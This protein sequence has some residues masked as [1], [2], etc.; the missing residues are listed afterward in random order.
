[1]SD[2]VQSPN[3]LVI[4]DNTEL[5]GTLIENNTTNQ[6]FNSRETMQVALD[7][8][9]LLEG[10]GIVILDAD[11]NEGDVNS[12]IDQALKLKQADPTQV[13]MIV[14][15]SEKLAAIL[16]TNI[17]P[18]IYRAFNKPISPNQIFLAFKSANALHQD[19]SAKQAAGEDI[20][21]VG[22]VENKTSIG[23]IA[24]QRKSN[25]MLY[26][27][28]GVLALGVIGWFLFASS[29]EEDTSSIVKTT[30]VETVADE[31]AGPANEEVSEINSLN[32]LAQTA[33]SEGRYTTPKGD[34]ALE[35]YNRVLELDPYDVTAY[36]GK[37]SVAEN[38]RWSFQ[39]LLDNAEFDQALT[40]MNDLQAIEPLNSDN[41]KLQKDLE[42][43]INSHVAKV[44]ESGTAEEIEQTTE[45]LAKIESEFTGSQAAAKAL[46]REQT[47]ITRI[48]KALETNNLIPPKSGNAYS[49]LSDAL[50]KNAISKA[51]I[52]PR[53][54]KL[55][56]QLMELT[57]STLESDNIEEADK[58]AALIK[59]LDTDTEGLK[60][61]S[62]TISDK[63]EEIAKLEQEKAN[64]QKEELAAA[65]SQ[66]EKVVEEPAKIIPAKIISRSVPKYPSRA[67]SSGVEGWVSVSFMINTKGIPE[68][69]KIVESQ[70]EGVFDKSAIKAVKKWRFSPARNERTGL[71]V[72]SLIS[73]T[74]LQ[75]KLG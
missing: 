3:V 15:E 40:V 58:L 60:T 52:T 6:T 29:G 64:K 9:D 45:V 48:D 44:K 74:K 14:G 27:A 70:P 57:Y 13:L 46:K 54:E 10:N 8:P 36:E 56:A 24:E 17:Q 53:L 51:N 59:R 33:I 69:I 71:P 5:V 12:T 42:K 34:N 2:G 25:S 62:E 39:G 75:F 43:A 22:P 4:T 31:V 20:S 63:K 47:L 65:E 61:L 55:S 26:I 32:Q 1:M 73:S 19:L 30:P 50:K 67:Q 7:D 72:E 16:K 37:K 41:Q 23:S 28:A 68:E 66:E 18:L 35:Y 49:L 38:L 21:Y 11:S